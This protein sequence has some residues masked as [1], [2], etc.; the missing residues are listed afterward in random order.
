MMVKSGIIFVVFLWGLA[1]VLLIPQFTVSRVSSGV[2]F[3]LGLFVIFFFRDPGRVVDAPKG[4]VLSPADGRIISCD[5]E[6]VEGFGKC[7]VVKIFLSIF[8]V[9]LQRAPIAGSIVGVERKKGAFKAAY[10]EEASAINA[11]NTITIKGDG[12]TVGVVQI[13]GLIARRIEC[14]V[15]VGNEVNIG[16]KIGFIRFGSQ[17]DVFLPE[18]VDL[19]IKPGDK[20]K[21]GL[22]V[23]GRLK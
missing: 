1:A 11:K 7:R 20:V 19:D 16:Q 22:T 18:G 8:N 10:K 14:W 2:F 17:V 13:V 6:Q 21:A 15:K 23:I 3:L 9:H 5:T 4:A 12:I